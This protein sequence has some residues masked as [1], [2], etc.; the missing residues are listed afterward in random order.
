ML[1]QF[2]VDFT[3]FVSLISLSWCDTSKFSSFE[4]IKIETMTLGELSEFL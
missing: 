3:V 1:R 4:T 2:C